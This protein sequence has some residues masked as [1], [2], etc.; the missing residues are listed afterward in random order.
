MARGPRKVHCRRRQEVEE[1]W[2]C[3]GRS[4]L[5]LGETGGYASLYQRVPPR[6]GGRG[7]GLGNE[8]SSLLVTFLCEGLGEEGSESRLRKQDGQTW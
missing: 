2:L 7:V 1:V 3:E 5:A 6:E 4:P 8:Q